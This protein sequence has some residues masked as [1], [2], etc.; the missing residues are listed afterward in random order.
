MPEIVSSV[1]LHFG[2][3]LGAPALILLTIGTIL[4]L[5]NES[6]FVKIHGIFAVAS[7]ILTLINVL[8]TFFL[9]PDI[10]TSFTAG[11][12]WSHIILG[13]LGLVAG[14]LSMLFGI[15]AERKPAKLTGYI[16]LVCWWGAFFSGFILV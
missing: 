13:A 8:S 5:V 14:F 15:A 2:I 4:V 10:W 12:H 1:S 16:T 3:L 11:I 6:K 9:N 7:W